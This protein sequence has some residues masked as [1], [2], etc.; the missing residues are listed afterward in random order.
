MRIHCFMVSKAAW[1]AYCEYCEKNANATIIET[2]QYG[3]RV[4]ERV[5]IPA[6]EERGESK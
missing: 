2:N 5:Y 1:D 3:E 4:E 6:R